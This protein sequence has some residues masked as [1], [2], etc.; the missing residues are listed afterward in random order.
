MNKSVNQ[1]EVG[2]ILHIFRDNTDL[3][4]WK[5]YEDEEFLLDVQTVA[6]VKGQF[7]TKVTVSGIIV[8]GG[9]R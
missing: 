9:N 3:L 7:N 4:K 8:N 2:Q 5:P 1:L 6:I